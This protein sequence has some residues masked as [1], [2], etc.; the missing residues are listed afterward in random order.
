[1]EAV[2]TK[3]IPSLD[4]IRAISILLVIAGHA[5][6]RLQMPD[7]FR[8][9]FEIT[10]YFGVTVFFVI[11]GFLITSLL[12]REYEKAGR[13]N[14]PAFFK[15]R[16]VRIVPAAAVYIATILILG[17]PTILQSLY[18]VTFTTSYVFGKAYLPLQHL[19]SLSVEEQFY[20]LWPIAFMGGVKVARRFCWL[21]VCVAP[22]CRLA[23]VGHDF[24]H[25]FPSVADS[26][27]FGCLLAFYQDDLKRSVT[28]KLSSP[29]AFVVLSS[30]TVWTGWVIYGS[31]QTL[32]RGLAPALIALTVAVA[33]ERKDYILNCLPMRSLGLLSY[34]LYLWQQPFLTL[35]GPYD[36]LPLRLALSLVVACA[37]YYFVEQPCL[38]LFRSSGGRPMLQNSDAAPTP[39]EGIPA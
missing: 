7:S 26:L 24:P 21:V 19:W 16:L 9:T 30:I 4:G 29:F 33:I 39:A 20:L 34:S 6:S 38:R 32:T 13:I 1:M 25:F 15:R 3:R 37:S 27:A 22:L 31:A 23:L 11:S 17:H 8:H 35:H 14:L 5:S 10:A 18:A 28:Q 36:I 2:T 12:K